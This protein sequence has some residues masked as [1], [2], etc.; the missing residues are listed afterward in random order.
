MP[1]K[2]LIKEK[3]DNNMLSKLAIMARLELPFLPNKK[4][5]NNNDKKVIKG[6]KITSKLMRWDFYSVHKVKRN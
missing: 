5:K 1:S 3:K 6:I 4:E 2:L